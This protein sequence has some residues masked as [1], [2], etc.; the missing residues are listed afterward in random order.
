MACDLLYAMIEPTC[1]MFLNNAHHYHHLQCIIIIIQLQQIHN[2]GGGEVLVAVVPAAD[3]SR[4]QSAGQGGGG[5]PVAEGR[6]HLAGRS[7]PAPRPPASRG[8]AAA[9]RE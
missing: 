8:G 3:R 6:H 5:E 7:R 2:V 1:Y 4:P 9:G